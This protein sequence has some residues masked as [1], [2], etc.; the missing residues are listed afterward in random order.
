MLLRRMKFGKI[1][2]NDDVI[3]KPETTRK[4]KSKIKIRL[5]KIS[6][7]VHPKP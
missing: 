1:D 7:P 4:P 3:L 6:S 5:S 2:E